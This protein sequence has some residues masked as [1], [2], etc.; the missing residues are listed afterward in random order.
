MWGLEPRVGDVGVGE[1]YVLLTD[2]VVGHD[3][4]IFVS[5]VSFLLLEAFLVDLL[6]FF[7]DV[8]FVVV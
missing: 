7:F 2:D 6:R 3:L 8:H 5:F 4:V 1:G